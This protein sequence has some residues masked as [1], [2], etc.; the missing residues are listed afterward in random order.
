MKSLDNNL[1]PKLLSSLVDKT[2]S[3]YDD[4]ELFIEKMVSEHFSYD[5]N[6][7]KTASFDTEQGFGLRV[8]NGDKT[9]FSHST[10][11]DIDSIKN[12]VK[13]VKSVESGKNIFLALP[14]QTNKKLYS[15]SNPIE[16]KEFKSKVSL[17]E[18]INAYGRKLDNKVS[19]VSI[20]L[21]G[22]YQKVQI[23]KINGQIYTDSR[24][25]V[26]LNVSVTVKN[27]NKIE[28]G[29]YGHGGRDMYSLIFKNDSWKNA[30]STAYQQALIRLEA[31]AAPAGEQTVVLGCGWPGILLHE[32]V[33]HGLEGDFNRKKTSAFHNLV[34]S[35]V[36]SDQI[37]IVDDGTL[38]KKRGSLSIDDE[39]TPTQNTVLIENGILKNFMQDRLNAR[40]MGKT[41]TG[42]GRRESFSSI[43]MPRMT[44]TYMINGNYHPDELIKSTK[45]GVY[46]TQ[47]SGGQVDITS[48]K[49]VF[50]ASEA[51]EI[52]NGKIGK[53]L[54]GA[55][56]IGNGP[57]IL[58]KVSMVANNMQ[59][60]NGIGTCGKDG[61][62]VPVGVGQPSL[63][64]D[65]LTVGGTV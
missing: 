50:S 13:A 21:A 22:N 44:N 47:F 35:K 9:G 57:E 62:R 20:T 37:T 59:I 49:F 51:Y 33:G 46:A 34:N 39:G 48:G 38:L 54:K 31:K 2:V 14:Q 64:I 53:P 1:D 19:Q 17:L 25:L 29:S 23:Y 10:D 60:D 65:N 52:K 5:N 58:K 26:R 11:L 15:D 24:P 12:S 30:V 4:G 56:L 27:K 41:P 45:K 55:T 43:P 28:T 18:K 36:A 61:Q 63:K 6:K 8:I 42:N 32:A 16:L 3:N 7:L 40:L